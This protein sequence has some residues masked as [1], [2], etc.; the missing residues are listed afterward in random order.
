MADNPFR[1]V[2][3]CSS[4]AVRERWFGRKVGLDGD[5]LLDEEAVEADLVINGVVTS[6]REVVS[7]TCPS[8]GRHRCPFRAVIALWLREVVWPRREDG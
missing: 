5:V 7:M 4:S 8:P 6:E 3:A 1:Q 2:V